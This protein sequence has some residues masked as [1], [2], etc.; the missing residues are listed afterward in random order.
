MELILI[1]LITCT[2]LRAVIFNQRGEK[3]W[4]AVIPLYNKYILGK[5]SDTKKLGII[6]AIFC[7]LTYII[8]ILSYSIE[9][10]MLSLIPS[11]TEF[12]NESFSEYIPDTLTN[13][14]DASKILLLLVAIIFVFSWSLMMR[15]FSE[16][17]KANTWWIIGWA[18]SPIICYIYFIF[19]HK[20]F[21]TIDKEI[22]V[23]TKN[24]IVMENIEESNNSTKKKSKAKK[25][26]RGKK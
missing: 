11:G 8:L 9:L 12:S 14:N 16:K 22:I 17:N 25:K 15:K 1:I 2:I 10:M 7:A 19:I 24:N 23:Y 21:Y 3:P 5:L 18:I 4:K 26:G 13:A 20:Y 6:T